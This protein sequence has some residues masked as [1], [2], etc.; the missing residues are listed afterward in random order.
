MKRLLPLLLAAPFFCVPLHARASATASPAQQLMSK[1]EW[2]SIGPYIGGRS[3][4]V[5]GVPS[6]P[7]LFYFGGVEAGVWRST[8]YGLSW[9]NITDGKIPGI[10]DPIG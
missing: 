1:L 7:N 3:V 10:A 4:A 6:N 8:D 2:R 5:A 9:E